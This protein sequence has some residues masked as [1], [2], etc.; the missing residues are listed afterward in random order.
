MTELEIMRHA[1]G[2]LD[3]MAEGIDPL[4]GEP[5]GA[6]EL[7][8]KERIAKCLRYVSG[9]L[10]QLIDL[11]GLPAPAEAQTPSAQPAPR[12]K[13]LPPFAISRDALAAFRL[14]SDPL[15]MTEFTKRV[16]E[17]VDPEAVDKL[18]AASILEFLEAQ[19]YLQLLTA[20]GK[21]GIRRPTAAGLQLGITLEDRQGQD[22]AYTVVVYNENAQ[23]YL[24]A[25]ME[26]IV[27]RNTEKYS[28]RVDGGALQGTPWTPEQDAQLREL[29][30]RGLLS[31][32]IA[33]QMQRSTSGIQARLHRLGLE[34]PKQER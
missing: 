11:G 15:T 31:A 22:G 13:R 17:L 24:L 1:K 16:N 23:A 4:T 7:V 5:V 6:N 32:E 34:A 33:R 19:G 2:Y 21:R 18:K 8:R 10:E 30:R 20:P 27:A 25:H 28:E 9:V 12:K 3:R 29:Y 14:S 26:E